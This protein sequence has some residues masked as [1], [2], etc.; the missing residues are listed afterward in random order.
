MGE[1]ERW[2]GL[3]LGEGETAHWVRGSVVVGA[4]GPNSPVR[5]FSEIE[6][7]GHAYP[8]HG[9]VCT[10]HHPAT[11]ATRMRNNTAFQRFLP[12]GPLAFLPLSPEY[13][14]MVWSTRPALA[15]AYTALGPTTLRYLVNL[16]FYAPD[17]STINR[18]NEMI[19]AGQLPPGGET[20]ELL[21]AELDYVLTHTPASELKQLPPLIDRIQG[22]SIA[23]FPLKLSH[24]ESYIG[25]RTVLVGDA[26]HTVHPLAGQGLNMGLADVRSLTRVW[27]NAAERG[28]DFGSS[29]ALLPYATERYPA[30]HLLLSTTDKLHH[31]FGTRIPVV[32]WARSVGLDVINELGPLKQA[33]MGQVGADVDR[34]KS[35]GVGGGLY[36]SAANGLEAWQSAKMVGR[37][38]V[39]SGKALVK[40][41]A[42]QLLE[43]LSR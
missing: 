26:A 6:S 41:G 10:M 14:T 38:A 23:S 33:L 21:K 35:G 20:E 7:F 4:D 24:A 18:I 13:S 43:R 25:K 16:G 27:E 15:A 1:G 30:N 34:K 8:T 11:T 36:E 32:N 12:T 19:L 40:N 3:H 22:N 39:D 5:K 29:T 42:R 2:V 28:G 37:L 9:V 31:I 17:E